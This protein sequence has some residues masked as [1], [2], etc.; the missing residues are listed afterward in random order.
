MSGITQGA[1]E[2][3][4]STGLG[5]VVELI[6]DKGL[7]IDAFVQVS[8]VGIEVL[9]I[10]ARVVVA[11]V[12][13]YLRYAQAIDQLDLAAA[14]I[15]AAAPAAIQPPVPSA[16]Q[17]GWQKTQVVITKAEPTTGAATGEIPATHQAIDQPIDQPV[18][19]PQ[20]GG[21]S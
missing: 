11:S 8:L 12:D 19:R 20:D 1:V 2:R 10:K 3:S 14:G 17:T 5:D 4:G 16:Q 9:T 21:G 7:V 13:T 18:A 6:L 15:A